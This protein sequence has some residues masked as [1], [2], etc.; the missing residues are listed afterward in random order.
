MKLS[1]IP[2]CRLDFPLA[3][4]VVLASWHLF[5]CTDHWQ[6]TG[7]RA[8]LASLPRSL[9][10]SQSTPQ[11]GRAAQILDYNPLNSELLKSLPRADS[12]LEAQGSA[13]PQP[14]THYTLAGPTHHMCLWFAAL[15]VAWNPSSC[16]Q[17]LSS[18][19]LSIATLLPVLICNI[20][21]YYSKL[22]IFYLCDILKSIFCVQRLVE[23]FR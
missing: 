18:R 17:Y 15:E 10:P 1:W 22:S 12:S 13:R 20:S 4:Q 3:Q 19:S 14:T 7:L 21:G 16:L 9:P 2:P 6:I 5:L 11:H 8:L 23:M